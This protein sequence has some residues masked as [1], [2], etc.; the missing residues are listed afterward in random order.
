MRD[1]AVEL[2]CAGL[3]DETHPAVYLDAKR[4]HCDA[5]FRRPRLDDGNQQVA[6]GLRGVAHRLIRIML[7]RDPAATL[8]TGATARAA[9][10]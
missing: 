3:F 4:R 10:V 6:A 8:R 7:T 1:I 5:D 9:S 2:C